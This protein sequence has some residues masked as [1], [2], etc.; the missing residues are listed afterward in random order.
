VLGKVLARLGTAETAADTIRAVLADAC[1][2]L[3]GL[4]E[5]F[6]A[7][8]KRGT[9]REWLAGWQLQYVVWF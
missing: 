4:A 1:R 6:A 9:A 3:P 5:L 2:G 7:R 8:E